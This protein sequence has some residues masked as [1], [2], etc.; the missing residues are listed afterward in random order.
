MVELQCGEIDNGH[1]GKIMNY[2]H[3]VLQNDPYRKFIISAL[4]NLDEMILFH[5]K[6]TTENNI[7]HMSSIPINFW[8]EGLKCISEILLKPQLVGYDQ[9]Y[10]PRIQIKDTM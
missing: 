9:K 5:A 6:R 7:M 2:N 10:D 3:Q 1:R 8:K 4:T